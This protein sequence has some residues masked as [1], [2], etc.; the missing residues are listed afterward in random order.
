M[1]KEVNRNNMQTHKIIF[2]FLKFQMYLLFNYF[3][4]LIRFKN[5]EIITKK[6][7]KNIT[8]SYNFKFKNIVSIWHTFKIYENIY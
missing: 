7:S 4:S 6:W 2:F 1:K 8:I 5:N 3:Y